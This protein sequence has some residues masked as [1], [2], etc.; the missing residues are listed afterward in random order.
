MKIE[1]L[2]KKGEEAF[3]NMDWRD[4][5]RINEEILNHA[6]DERIRNLATGFYHYALAKLG[7]DYAQIILNLDNAGQYFK[8]ADENLASFAETERLILLSEFDEKNKGKHLKNLG[9]FTQDLYMRTGDASHLQLAIGALE[10]ARKHFKKEELAQINLNLTFCYGSYASS[11]ENP[12]EMYEKLIGLCKEMEKSYKGA[13]LA[14][15]KMNASMAYQNLASLAGARPQDL[16]TTFGMKDAENPKDDLNKAVKLNE[17]AIKL[18]ERV[19]SKPEMLKAKQ[20]LANILRDAALFDAD[21]AAE[22]LKRAIQMRKEVAKQFLSVGS[23]L[24]SAYETF[25]LG[26]AF[27]ELSSLDAARSKKHLTE[28]IARFEDAAKIFE[29]EKQMEDLGQA[30]LGIAVAYKNRSNLKKA[31]KM[32]EEAVGIFE[33]EK[34]YRDMAEKDKKS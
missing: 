27:L 22:H 21:N 4:V 8:L 13:N 7:K 16:R 29:N 12:R 30:K 10:N 1:E 11:S 5:V 9:E 18:F 14:R 32:F 24:N 28:A 23:E 26:T 31:V 33:K 20:S 34:A 3:H 19:N 15:A 17:E 25:D 6:T 2:L